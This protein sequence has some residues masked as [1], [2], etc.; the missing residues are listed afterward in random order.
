VSEG[1]RPKLRVVGSRKDRVVIG[2][3]RLSLAPHGAAHSCDA[4][5]LEEDTWQVVA[6]GPEMS[7]RIEHPIRFWTDVINAKPLTPGTVLLRKGWPLTMVAVVYDFG[8]EPCCR[9]RWIAAALAE[10]LRI[11]RERHVSALLL[12]LPGVRHGRLSL[13]KSF[14]LVV[15]ALEEAQHGELRQVLL[16][17]PSEEAEEKVRQLIA[18]KAAA[19]Q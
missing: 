19:C 15:R 6:A 2:P 12:P 11:C 8:A 9:S 17:C 14:R 16:A 13:R 5:V 18:A 1:E 3:V 7:I 10:I 4:V